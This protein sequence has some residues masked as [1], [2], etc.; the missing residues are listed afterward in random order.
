MDVKTVKI[1]ELIS[2][3]YNPR[4]ITPDALESLKRSI[5]EFGYV[6]PIIVNKYNNH[7]L[8]GNQ[9]VTALKELGYETVEVIYT[10]IEDLNREKA[11]N[12]RLNNLSGDWDIGKLDTIFQD[13]EL[14]G[15]DL[16]LTGFATENLQPFETETNIDNGIPVS[17]TITSDLNTG[18]KPLPSAGQPETTTEYIEPEHEIKED[19]YKQDDIKVHVAKG[20]LYQLGNHYLFCGDATSENDLEIL[21]NAERERALIDLVF[22][23]P[24]YGMK[25]EKDGV[26]NDN[27]NYN[28]L[29]LFNKKWIPL[30]FKA[31][32]SNGSW[33]CWGIDQPLMDIY[34]FILKPMIQNK[35]ISFRNLLT[36]DK[37]NGQG[38]LSPEFRMYAPADEKCLFVM[39]GSESC[40][41]FTVNQDDYSDNMDTVRVYLEKEINKLH[42]IGLND[43]TIANA[44]GYKDGRTVNHWYSKSQFA[45]PT[46]E[47][48]EALRK[49]GQQ[50]LKQDYDFLKQD[51]DELKQDYDELKQEF[52][53]NRSYFNNTHDNMNNVWHFKRTNNTEK[54]LTGGH[55]TPKPIKLC[56]RAILS[57]SRQ[58]EN[59]LDL[60]GGSGSTLIACEAS[61]R[62][63]YM[64]ELDPYYCQIIINRW[65]TF[66]GGKAVKIN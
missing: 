19:D 66:T 40:Q 27:L 29:L 18:L 51:Y 16:T 12:I 8:A 61:N 33:Y 49:Y 58:G 1:S 30:T 3:E 25:K 23:D 45:L 56:T 35:E 32:K 28:D 37:G 34:A 41:G 62:N 44:L 50:V 15:F 6:A 9:R 42:N 55:A 53:S 5:D 2:P 7:I 39:V 38:Q 11:L 31:L 17:E 52:Y 43:K 24:P 4:H 64:M 48:Y 65:E 54:E 46:R 63:C 22:T 20:D 47:N 26:A 60:F 36:W 59:V 13:L 14:D 57:S 21:L 10:H